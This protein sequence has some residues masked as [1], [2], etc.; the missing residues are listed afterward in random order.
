MGR[1]V[2]DCLRST[3]G[4]LWLLHWA[5]YKLLAW[6]C[7]PLWMVHTTMTI[8]CPACWDGKSAP[9]RLGWCCF[10]TPSYLSMSSFLDGIYQGLRRL[11][12]LHSPLLRAPHTAVSER[13]LRFRCEKIL[14]WAFWCDGFFAIQETKWGEPCS[15]GARDVVAPNWCNQ[16]LRPFSLWHIE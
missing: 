6:P 3:C 4:L 8:A 9:C 2:V 5:T 13:L 12:T 14:T 7:S 1:S 15:S 16:F 10:A 11:A